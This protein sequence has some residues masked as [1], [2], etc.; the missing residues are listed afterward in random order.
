MVT[1]GP[2]GAGVT[3]VVNSWLAAD[4]LDE[5]PGTLIRNT[6]V[7]VPEH[8]IGDRVA[9]AGGD[10][11]HVDHVEPCSDLVLALE[12]DRLADVGRRHGAGERQGLAGRDGGG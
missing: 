5:S 12:V 6:S 10:G 11:A 4:W 1:G 3:V 9:A 8:L 7:P 2:G